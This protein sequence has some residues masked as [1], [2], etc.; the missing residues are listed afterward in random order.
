MPVAERTG[1]PV[2]TDEQRS[3]ALVRANQIRTYRAELKDGIRRGTSE[4]TAFDAIARPNDREETW[5]VFDLLLAIPKVGRVKANKMLRQEGIS[6]SKT[7]D[8]LT[9]RQRLALLAVLP[10]QR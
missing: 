9:R 10:R 7:L 1:A 6:P 5:K 4:R 8:G 2:R 3:D